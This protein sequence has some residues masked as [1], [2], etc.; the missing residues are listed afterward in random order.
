MPSD[1]EVTMDP[2]PSR[3]DHGTEHADAESCY[4]ETFADPCSPVPSYHPDNQLG[5][6]ETP[7][8]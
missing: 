5:L 4:A 8:P 6:E 1:G 7:D 2:P 3:G